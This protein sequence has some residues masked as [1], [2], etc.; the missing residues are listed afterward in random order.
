MINNLKH[1]ASNMIVKMISQATTNKEVLITAITMETE[2]SKD[3]TEVASS[4]FSAMGKTE[5]T[6]IGWQFSFILI[7][8]L[9]THFSVF[10]LSCEVRLQ[11]RGLFPVPVNASGDIRV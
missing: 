1:Q 4:T 9:F 10:Q 8:P 2:A 3:S 6:R 11:G 5:R 7:Q